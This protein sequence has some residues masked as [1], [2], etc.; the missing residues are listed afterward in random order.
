MDLLH[1]RNLLLKGLR[2]QVQ[3]GKSIDFWNDAGIPSLPNF[4]IPMVKPSNNTIC[5]VADIIDPHTGQWDIQKL[6]NKAPAEVVNAVKE[7][8]ISHVERNDS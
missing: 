5:M 8:P 3:N 4:K 2:W 1:G 6:A 7:I